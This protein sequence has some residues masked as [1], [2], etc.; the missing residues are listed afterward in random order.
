MRVVWLAGLGWGYLDALREDG[1][2]L[3]HH[4]LSQQT[5]WTVID[6]EWGK[7]SW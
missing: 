7:H 6:V 3:S 4:D 5:I 2:D 1:G